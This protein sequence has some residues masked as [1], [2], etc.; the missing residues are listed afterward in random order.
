MIKKISTFISSK[1]VKHNIISEDSEDV[2]KYGI[3][4]TISSI[5]SLSLAVVIGLLFNI[6]PQ[7]ILYYFIF[8]FLRSLTGGYHAKTYFKCNLIFGIITFLV[9]VFSK[10]A[11]SMQISINVIIFLFLTS[12]M[13]FVWMAPVENINKPIKKNKVVYYKITSV[14][15]SVILCILSV[16]LYINQH[17]LEA[18]VIT[19]TV[20]VV[21]ILCVV[22]IF[23]KGVE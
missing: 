16:F 3:E 23:R 8:V 13:I 17:I 2:Y 22:T 10:L 19:M 18:S 4:I 12:I 6:L 15:I 5:I 21:S 20:F 11:Y 14:V 7:T 1:F 9:M